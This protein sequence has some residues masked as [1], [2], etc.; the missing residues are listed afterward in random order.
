MRIDGSQAWLESNQRPRHVEP[1]KSPLSREADPGQ[2]SASPDGQDVAP[3]RAD[4]RGDEMDIHNND[5]LRE[6]AARLMASGDVKPSEDGSVRQARVDEVR[7]NYEAGKYSREDIIAGIVDRLL[8][9]W[10]I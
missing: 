8:D 10:K 1:A 5:A 3:S 7:K 2:S 9:Q 4:Q 6:T